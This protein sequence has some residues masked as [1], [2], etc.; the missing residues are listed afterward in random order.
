MI[1]SLVALGLTGLG[2]MTA[3]FIAL[4]R[5]TKASTAPVTVEWAQSFSLSAYAPMERLLEDADFE[6]IKTQQ[7]ANPK[8]LRE[9]RARRV[10]IFA[11]YLGMMSRDFHRLYTLLQEYLVSAGIDDPEIAQT[12]VQQRWL[13]FRSLLTA[14]VR[15]RLYAV[16]I[17]TVSCDNLL[18]A[19]RKMGALAGD[20]T[21]LMQQ[22]GVARS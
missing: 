18:E 6:F 15:L 21:E 8:I 20:L 13:F 11:A 16:G 19:M 17:G 3:L 12:L 5:L 2:L 10:R 9:L 22:P 4:Y 1:Y 7:G 14:Q